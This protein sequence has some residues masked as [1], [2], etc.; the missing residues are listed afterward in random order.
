[1][2]NYRKLIVLILALGMILFLAACGGSGDKN[3]GNNE[4]EKGTAQSSADFFEWD[5]DYIYALTEKG[6]KQK[7]LVIPE[8]CSGFIGSVFADVEN[9]VEEVSFAGNRITSLDGVFTCAPTIKKVTLPEGLTAIKAMD[10]WLCASLETVVIPET[11]TVID[12]YA[13]QECPVLKTV[14]IQCEGLNRVGERAFDMCGALEEIVLPDSV[15]EIGEYAFNECVALTEIALPKSLSAIGA[16]AFMNSGLLYV[17]VPAEMELAST[18]AT[19][20][21]Q[22]HNSV[23]FRIVE[24]S[25]AD[26]HFEEAF[27]DIY[28]REYK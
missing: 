13:F 12:D 15:T 16:G 20:F 22:A 6:A 18:D 9:N 8:T 21:A 19:S 2:K 25:W 24:G 27:G 4:L 1:M 14:A 7:S 10:F 23:I 28:E 5:G 11:C 17:D 26:L 3:S